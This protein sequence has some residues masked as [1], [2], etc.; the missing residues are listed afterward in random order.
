VRLWS[1]TG[2]DRYRQKAR[3]LLGEFQGIMERAPHATESLLLAAAQYVD[4]ERQKGL[5]AAAPIKNEPRVTAGPVTVELSAATTTF[6]RGASVPVSVKFTIE[7]GV[8]IQAHKPDDRFVKPTHFTLLSK[9]LGA[10]G[11]AEFPAPASIELPELGKIKI[12][13]GEAVGRAELK[14]SATAPLGKTA[15]RVKAYFQACNDKEC[16]QPE[17]VILSL[18]VEIAE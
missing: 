6:K 2:E 14:I 4:L 7:K 8:H 12:Y 1:L 16:D 15:L 5:A 13:T 18:P 3:A 9:D 11:E 17:E 10:F